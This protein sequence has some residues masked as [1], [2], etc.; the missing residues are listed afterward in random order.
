LAGVFAAR[1]GNFCP[2]QAGVGGRPAR[3]D[4]IG[5]MGGARAFCR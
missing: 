2:L 3:W 4:Q 5:P 1:S